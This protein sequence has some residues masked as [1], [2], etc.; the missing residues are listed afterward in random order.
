[1][2]AGY[3]FD[4]V[5]AD[6]VYDSDAFRSKITTQGGV[7]VIRPRRNRVEVRPY[8]AELYK[9]RNIIERFWHRLK[10]YQRVAT[11][12]DK[13]ARRYLAFVYFS[14]LLITAKKM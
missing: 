12:Y 1:M 9:L 10:Q 14:A 11:R 5:I 13:Y 8:D 7:A 3:R 2:I 4:A 6:T